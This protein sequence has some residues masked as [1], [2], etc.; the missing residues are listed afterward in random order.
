MYI[1]SKKPF[2]SEK[3]IGLSLLIFLLIAVFIGFLP[4]FKPKPPAAQADFE[5]SS[6]QNLE[7]RQFTTIQDNALLPIPNPLLS[8]KGE[9]AIIEQIEVI[10]TAYSSTVWETDSHPFLTAAGTQVRDSVVANNLLPF[11][12]KIR[13]PELFGDKIFVVEDRMN[14]RKSDYHIDIW[15]PSHEQAENFGSKFAKIEIVQ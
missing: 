15:F 9:Y 3:K 11:G 6:N 10:V 13:I 8:P 1:N 12:T 4:F 5:V 2:L 7:A 14:S